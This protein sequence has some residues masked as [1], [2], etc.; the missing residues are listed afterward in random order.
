VKRGVV[1]EVV[2]ESRGEVS[3][4]VPDGGPSAYQPEPAWLRALVLLLAAGVVSFGLVGLALAVVGWYRPWLVFPLGSLVV[5]I[6]LV[7][8]R[9]FVAGPQSRKSSHVIA[10]VGVAAIACLTFW[11]ASY[12]SQHVYI[13]RDGGSYMNTGRW[14]A[15][16]GDLVVPPPKAPFAREPSLSYDSFGVFQRPNGSLVFQFAHF[17]PV[18]LAEAYA[19]GGD[20]TMFH[21]PELLSGIALLAFFLLAWRLYRRPWFAL[22]ATLCFAFLIPEV[23]FSR[24]SYSEIPTQVLV[25]SALALLVGTRRLP[26]PGIAF[27]AG[28]LLGAT[29]ATRIDG[30]AFLIAVPAFLT[31]AWLTND[32]TYNRKSVIWFVV[33]LGPGVALGLFDVVERSRPYFTARSGNIR[34]LVLATAAVAVASLVVAAL[35]RPIVRAAGRIQRAVA[36]GAGVGVIVVGFAMWLLRPLVQTVRVAPLPIT[37]L[38]IAEHVRVD[39]TRTYYEH[40]LVWMAWYL[41]PITVAV[42]I[43][44]AG[45]LVRSLLSSGS[46][47][48]VAPLFVLAPLAAIYLWK[49]EAVPDHVWVDRRF[50]DNATPLLVLLAFGLG[51]WL[52]NRDIRSNTGRTVRVVVALFVASALA[53]PLANLRDI[54]TMSEQRGVLDIVD[55]ACRVMGPRPAIVLLRSPRGLFDELTPQTFR[56]W[57]DAEVAVMRGK[58]DGVVLRRVAESWRALGRRTYVVADAASTIAVALPDVQILTK[59]TATPKFLERTL[60]RRPSHLIHESYAIVVAPVPAS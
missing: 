25:F 21:A 34:S 7:T 53:Y 15:G 58:A 23:S 3:A 36:L 33:G 57:C 5:V 55:G 60:S 37:G 59:L 51:A 9:G 12:A 42:A 19:I 49:A 20:R 29:Q 22:A 8:C 17:L 6:L 1:S 38:Q 16:H 43:V 32:E 31:I 52:A 47:Q 2:A 39:A 28:L 27:A 48:A 18:V 26:R 45:L 14:I 44:A 46:Q 41:G 24:D 50:L 54:S 30:L 56:G 11:N 40:S 10:A 35:W 4:T 13:N